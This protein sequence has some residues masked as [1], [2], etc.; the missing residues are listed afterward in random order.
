MS[1]IAGESLADLDDRIEA[2]QVISNRGDEAALGNAGRDLDRTVGVDGRQGL[3]GEER[4]AALDEPLEDG[5]RGRR[6]DAHVGDVRAL[7]IEHSI[8]VV[9]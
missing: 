1:G 8:D 5:D 2:A 9:I 3:L 4:D 6:R 7:L